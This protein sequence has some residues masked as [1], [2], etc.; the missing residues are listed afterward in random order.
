MAITSPKI[1]ET[2]PLVSRYKIS[3]YTL[4]VTS[5]IYRNGQNEM[6]LEETT[7]KR[8]MRQIET[9]LFVNQ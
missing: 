5:S 9:T 2:I 3:L 6:V 4:L 8:H 7:F 1:Q